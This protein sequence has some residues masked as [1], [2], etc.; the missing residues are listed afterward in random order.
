MHLERGSTNEFKTAFYLKKN[1]Q[2][3]QFQQIS[4]IWHP[5]LFDNNAEKLLFSFFKFNNLAIHQS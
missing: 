5:L 3:D 2:L 4:L 1:P